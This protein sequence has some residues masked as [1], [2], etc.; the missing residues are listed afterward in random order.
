MHECTFLRFQLSRNCGRRNLMKY[1]VVA[2]FSFQKLSEC[3]V[4]APSVAMIRRTAAGVVGVRIADSNDGFYLIR[5]HR[6][7]SKDSIAVRH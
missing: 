5:W 6:S 7:V 1:V 4:A 2:G 3:Q